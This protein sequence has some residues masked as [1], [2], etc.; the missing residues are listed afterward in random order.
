MMV[1]FLVLMLLFGFATMEAISQVTL[2]YS[3]WSGG[4]PT[5][6][7]MVEEVIKDFEKEHPDI[8]I[9][10]FSFTATGA[11]VKFN[12]QIAAGT[13]PD[14]VEFAVE[15]MPSY[16]WSGILTELQ[17]FVDRDE[18]VNP[19][20]FFPQLWEGWKYKGKLYG[21][22]INSQPLVLYYNKD[23]F[24][25]AGVSYPDK[26]WTWDNFLKATQRLTDEE[27]MRWGFS[28]GKWDGYWSPFVY[29]NGGSVLNA[30]GTKC[31]LDSPQAIEAI[32]F[33]SDLINKYHVSP[34]L[35]QMTG[36]GGID[37]MFRTGRLGMQI[38]GRWFVPVGREI[39]AFKWDASI[40]PKQ[41]Q[42][43]FPL[44]AL[45]G[46]ISAQCEN[47]NAAWELLKYMTGEK[48]QI[49]YAESGNMVPARK[50][51]AGSDF[52]LESTPPENNQAFL[53][54]LDFGAVLPPANW[55]AVYAITAP[56]M[57]IILRGKKSVEEGVKKI[58]ADVNKML[59]L[60]ML[61]RK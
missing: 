24:D 54:S 11:Y 2:K 45:G 30:D 20:D 35:S 43:G 34:T 51:L 41:R 5:A 7:R 3:Y 47:P 10:A 52:Y 32:Q 37:T 12:T 33:V 23:L 38:S 42:R 59:T 4:G 36:L 46:V 57:D 14:V 25:S 17:P 56:E 1:L 29:Q 49:H 61:R 31:V 50:A 53:D 27:Q 48:S 8:K 19:E 9:N 13:V 40:L 28:V 58:V 6:A 22:P 26:T 39:K 60:P 18:D 44:Y 16:A 55:P 15:C 21:I